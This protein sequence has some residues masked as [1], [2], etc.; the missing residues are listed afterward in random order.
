MINIINNHSSYTLT[1]C[2]LV[3]IDGDIFRV[4]YRTGFLAAEETGHIGNYPI[5]KAYKAHRAGLQQLFQC[6]T[7]SH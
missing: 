1:T 5:R 7:T 6:M 4:R 2:F 3:L